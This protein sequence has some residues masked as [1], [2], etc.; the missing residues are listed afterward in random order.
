MRYKDGTLVAL[1]DLVRLNNDEI[2][3]VVGVIEDQQFLS[4]FRAE[5]WQYLKRGLLVDST[6]YGL[7]HYEELG[8]EVEF[9]ERGAKSNHP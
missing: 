4:G 7:F 8:D 9:V 5:E 2:G 1:G 6:K 3:S